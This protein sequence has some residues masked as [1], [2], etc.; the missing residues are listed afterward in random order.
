MYCPRCGH[1]TVVVASE[2][3]PADYDCLH[4][5]SQLDREEVRRAPTLDEFDAASA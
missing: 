2:H 4:C 5:G 3:L 1:E